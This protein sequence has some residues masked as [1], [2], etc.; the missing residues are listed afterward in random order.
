MSEPNVNFASEYGKSIELLVTTPTGEFDGKVAEGSI[1]GAEDLYWEQL[2]GA[3][4]NE[5]TETNG[6]QVYQNLEHYRRKVFT[7][8]Y[9]LPLMLDKR[10]EMRTAVDFKSSYVQRTVEAY[11]RSKT[12][13]A[14]K[15]VYNSAYTGKNGT[16]A[17]AFDYSNQTVAVGTG[18]AS[19]YTTAGLTKEKLIAAR[20][21][22]KKAG[23]DLQMAMYK[24]YFSCTQDELDNLLALT[25]VTSRDYGS[26]VA[27]QSGEVSN[28]MGFEFIF[29]EMIPFANTALTGVHLTWNADS[30][31]G[32][33]APVD[34]DSTTTHACFAYVKDN[35][36]LYSSQSLQ[37]EAGKI[38]RFR[39]NWGLYGSWSHG[40]VRRQEKGAVYVP[41]DTVPTAA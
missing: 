28:W 10:D 6:Q 27:L 33:R 29:S 26:L 3:I 22:L 20:S 31:T 32:T 25:E 23:Y 16:T 8:D 14:I 11:K 40:G 15:A 9:E 5:I 21:K 34:T 41:C 37:T 39:Y 38:E 17:V 13:E 2:G 24:P 19:G 35:I 4:E 18:A 12:I 1:T 30:T 7:A 36:G